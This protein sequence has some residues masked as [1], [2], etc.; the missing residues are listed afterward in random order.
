MRSVVVSM[1]VS[2]RPFSM[3]IPEEPLYKI[4]H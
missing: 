3:L 4:D 2:S 1:C